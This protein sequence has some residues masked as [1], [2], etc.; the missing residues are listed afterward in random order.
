MSTTIVTM[1][2]FQIKSY[3]LVMNDV[4]VRYYLLKVY[5]THRPYVYIWQVVEK[6]CIDIWK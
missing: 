2:I 3:T 4:W 6:E 1:A 5:I